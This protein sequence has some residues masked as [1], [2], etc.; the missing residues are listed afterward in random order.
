MYAFAKQMSFDVKAMGNN[1]TRNRTLIK[2][3]K[4]PGLVISASGISNTIFLPSD[5]DEFCDG[6]NL[7][8]QE[9][10]AGTKSDFLIE[11]VIA[12]ID[13]L[14]E[15][16]SISEKQHNQILIKCNLLQTKKN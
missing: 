1:S 14:L 5:P 16:E 8:L 3:L 15:Y 11:E 10:K 13:K 9:K 7:L 2:L 6:L 4:S 12:I